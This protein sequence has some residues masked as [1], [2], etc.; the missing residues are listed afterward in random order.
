MPDR[1]CR[2]GP[3]GGLADVLFFARQG[4]AVEEGLHRRLAEA[5]VFRGRWAAIS[6]DH[7]HAFHAIVGSHFTVVGR[8]A[9]AN[10]ESVLTGAVKRFRSGVVLSH[11]FSGEVEAMGV[12][13][14]PVEDRVGERRVAD[15]L[16]P[17]FDR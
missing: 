16:V 17:V 3:S 6:R 7:G 2:A 13:H 4:A 5:C 12:V 1:S 11:A 9:D 8:L 15:G 10:M 14:E